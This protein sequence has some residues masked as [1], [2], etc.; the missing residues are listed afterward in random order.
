MHT[1]TFEIKTEGKKKMLVITC[2]LPDKPE[3]SKSG[4][5]L[6]HATT[7]GNLNTGLKVNGK[8]LIAGIN[9]YTKK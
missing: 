5:S 4:K 1:P 9:V 8:D 7:N 6:L 3:E 2:E